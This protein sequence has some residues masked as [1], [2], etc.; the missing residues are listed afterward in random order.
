MKYLKKYKLFESSE[1]SEDNY[2]DIL[3]MLKD[4]SL[5]FSDDLLD[6]NIGHSMISGRGEINGISI[7]NIQSTRNNMGNY[8]SKFD[9][10]K[11]V[12]TI[13]SICSYMRDMGYESEIELN[14]VQFYF[15]ANTNVETGIIRNLGTVNLT[16]N[17]LEN[18][19]FISNRRTNGIIFPAVSRKIS[20]IKGVFQITISFN[21]I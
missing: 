20:N 6:Y 11:Y 19:I 5:E 1:E 8:L 9:F 3:D 12:G 18:G 14:Q 16:Q 7:K 10:V 2:Y 17:D 4:Y 13:I 15:D 21:K